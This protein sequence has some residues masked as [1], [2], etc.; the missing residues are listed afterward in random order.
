M[1]NNVLGT[2]LEPCS[3]EPLTGL[4]R[5]GRCRTGADDAGLHVVCA[6]M[7][8]AF[9]E[10]SR[11][12]G[13]DLITPRPE[14]LFPGLQPG[15]QWC[16]CAARWQEALDAGVAPPVVLESTH[17]SALEF[18]QLDDLMRHAADSLNA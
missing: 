16:L 1:P 10:F 15:D 17:I 5:D 13:N 9:L 3:A 14:F 11:T 4:Y 6:R 7:T 12:R 18:V 2:E 8:A